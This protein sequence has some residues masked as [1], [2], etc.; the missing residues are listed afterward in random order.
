MIA[1]CGCCTLTLVRS[2]TIAV[3]A[4]LALGCSSKTEAPDAEVQASG[5]G[6]GLGAGA[7][8][9]IVRDPVAVLPST[10]AAMVGVP[11]TT[12]GPDGP[13]V[14]A[15][16]GS[17]SELHWKGSRD[18]GDV[19]AG[20]SLR[21]GAFG[22]TGERFVAI[23]SE[24]ANAY[25]DDLGYNDWRHHRVLSLD[26]AHGDAQTLRT[27]LPEN[28]C[29]PSVTELGGRVLLMW[30]RRGRDNCESGEAMYQLLGRRGEALSNA[31]SLGEGDSTAVVRSLRARW[32]FGRAVVVAQR[33]DAPLDAAWV[34]DAS[35]ES[36]WTGPTGGLEGVVACP[37]S[38][39][40]RVRVGREGSTGEVLGATTLRFERLVGAGSI[41]VPA[42]VNDV[43]GAVVSGNR[44]LTLH[45]PS[46]S[47]GGC[48]INVV[49]LTARAVVAQH[50]ADSM[51]CD[52]RYVRAMPRGFV[53]TSAE[54]PTG[55]SRVL[56]CAW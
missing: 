47:T 44:V 13:R 52:E 48:D 34:I 2:I 7:Y 20:R 23:V 29:A 4:S 50:H 26:G 51:T 3:C 35:G 15:R 39:C 19:P 5:A 25:E 37:A 6:E 9:C 42:T 49:D 17:G 18:E 56:D 53:I 43:V 10:S 32:D 38:G 21:E 28:A 31:R 8:R 55:V 1:R 54:N 33:R 22:W 40:V 11:W 46:A 24:R 16:V 36:L 45:T 41:T 12:R 30:Y 27:A 14:Y